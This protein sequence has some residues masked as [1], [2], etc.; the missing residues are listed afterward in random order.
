MAVAA[1]G[2]R[3]AGRAIEACAHR[4]Q[5]TI[6]DPLIACQD[7]TQP[8]HAFL[9]V[10]VQR[11]RSLSQSEGQGGNADRSPEGSVRKS[12]GPQPPSQVAS[13]SE[14]QGPPKQGPSFT[15]EDNDVSAGEEPRIPTPAVGSSHPVATD[16]ADSAVDLGRSGS[17]ASTVS[18]RSVQLSRPPTSSP[19]VGDG[20]SREV[21]RMPRLDTWHQSSEQGSPAQGATPRDAPAR[22]VAS[23]F[24]DMQG[25]SS[26]VSKPQQGSTR[27]DEDR[28]SFPSQPARGTAH[29][30]SPARADPHFD[31][32]GP[33]HPGPPLSHSAEGAPLEAPPPPLPTAMALLSACGAPDSRRALHLAQQARAEANDLAT[34]WGTLLTEA[35]REVESAST[36]VAAAVRES[37]SGG[38]GDAMSVVATRAAAI[39]NTVRGHPLPRHSRAL[40]TDHP[41]PH[42]HS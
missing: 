4:N 28:R 41:L 24:E 14:R 10:C 22:P 1:P 13:P 20:T 32:Q 30:W 9:S 7:W 29:P 21:N 16:R 33:P 12:G 40:I 15:I 35:Q 6:T 26:Q 19:R 27:A 11:L 34:V 38:G 18:E 31:P 36:E 2:A 39:T 42:A 37:E 23:R 17:P 3:G 25:S 8:L 5:G